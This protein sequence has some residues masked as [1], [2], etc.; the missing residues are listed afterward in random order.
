MQSIMGWRVL[1]QTRIV[2]SR[3][4]QQHWHVVYIRYGKPLEIKYYGKDIPNNKYCM[5]RHV[6]CHESIHEAVY[7]I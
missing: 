6:Q 7:Y 5:Q 2:L 1:L 3:V 4:Q